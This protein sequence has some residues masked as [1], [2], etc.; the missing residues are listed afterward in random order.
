MDALA[1]AVEQSGAF[2][3]GLFWLHRGEAPPLPRVSQ[4]LARAVKQPLFEA[5]FALR[6]RTLTGDAGG[7]VAL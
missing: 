2:P 4:L 7:G 5:E 1:E 6:Q 3:V